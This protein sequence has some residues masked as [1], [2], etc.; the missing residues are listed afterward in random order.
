MPQVQY[1]QKGQ[2]NSIESKAEEE[3]Q[4]SHRCSRGRRDSL[5]AV[6]PNFRGGIPEKA[7]MQQ[8]QKGQPNTSENKAEEGTQRSHRCTKDRRDN[9]TPVRAMQ[10]REPEKPRVQQRQK[11]QPNTSESKAEEEITEATDESRTEGTA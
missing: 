7:Q 6:K 5:T 10:R 9:L 11:G 1:G 2:P 4:R 3:T 8:G